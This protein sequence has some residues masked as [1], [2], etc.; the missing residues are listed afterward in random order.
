MPRRPRRGEGDL[1]RA[2]NQ[3]CEY[4]ERSARKIKLD[5]AA[6]VRVS[7][8]GGVKR[9]QIGICLLAIRPRNCLAVVR[10]AD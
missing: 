10:R 8:A 2:V 7:D 6:L 1:R 3:R 4:P 5:A 9:P